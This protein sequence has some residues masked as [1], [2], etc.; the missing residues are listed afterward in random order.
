[1]KLSGIV[2]FLG[3]AIVSSA[4]TTV[5]VSYTSVYDVSS[6]SLDT[7]AC[8]DGANGLETKNYT[9]FGSLPKFPYI[10]GASAVAGWNSANCGTCWQLTYTNT[11]SGSTRSI[12]VL[13]IDYT[14]S[15]FNI[16]EEAMN[17]LTNGQAGKL[18]RINATSKQVASSICG[19]QT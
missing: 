15:G 10:G 12:N 19:L 3:C 5:T 8:S 17:D 4:L 14:T 13:V 2:Y 16:A 1:M 9:T 7:V 6:N 11:S 18:G